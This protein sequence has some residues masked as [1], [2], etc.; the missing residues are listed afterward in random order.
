[1]SEWSLLFHVHEDECIGEMG[2]VQSRQMRSYGFFQ[3]SLSIAFSSS[4]AF[5]V[6]KGNSRIISHP[7]A[8]SC[9]QHIDPDRP[10]GNLQAAGARVGSWKLTC[11]HCWLVCSFCVAAVHRSHCCVPLLPPRY[12][13]HP[14]GAPLSLFQRILSLLSRDSRLVSADGSG[15]RGK[16]APVGTLCRDAA[17]EAA[18]EKAETP[19]ATSLIGARGGGRMCGCDGARLQCPLPRRGLSL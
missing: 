2:G 17:I 10:Y 6:S 14:H 7:T 12:R 16:C 9:L 19:F 5:Y 13:R 8:D 3:S 4:I 15:S 11:S 1:M 18:A